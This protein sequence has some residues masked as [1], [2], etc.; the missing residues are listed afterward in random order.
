MAKYS[1]CMNSLSLHVYIYSQVIMTIE[2]ILGLRLN[3]TPA[4][5]AFPLKNL[6]IIV[7]ITVS[8]VVLG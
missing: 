3:P 1:A 7:A 8:A 2:G 4:L 5:V 6:H